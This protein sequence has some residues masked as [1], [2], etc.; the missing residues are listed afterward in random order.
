MNGGGPTVQR[1]ALATVRNNTLGDIVQFQYNPESIARTFTPPP[2]Q[3]P[4]APTTQI[5]A[6]APG[7]QESPSSTQSGPAPS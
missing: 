1:G 4:G 2:H 3:G 7:Q 6:Q 5:P